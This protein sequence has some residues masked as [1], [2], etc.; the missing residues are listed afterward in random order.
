MNQEDQT[1]INFLDTLN[2]KFD[3]NQTYP[4]THIK[5]EINAQRPRVETKL[6]LHNLDLVKLL[7]AFIGVCILP[8]III[9]VGFSIL[10][11][12]TAFNNAYLAGDLTSP[13]SNET[14]LV[15]VLMGMS[16]TI[17]SLGAVLLK[18][19]SLLLNKPNSYFIKLKGK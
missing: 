3:P 14:V 18:L 9:L 19:N 10:S 13:V 11:T 8:S 12:A 7:K 6:T 16:F 5:A 2:S 4:G 15:F 17:F 1:Y